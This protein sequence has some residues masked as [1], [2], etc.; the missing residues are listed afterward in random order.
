MAK[1]AFPHLAKLLLL[2][3]KN[4]RSPSGFSW[5]F[6]WYT[7]RMNTIKQFEKST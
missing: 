6:S 7:I 3:K 2:Q 5:K 1:R 4:H